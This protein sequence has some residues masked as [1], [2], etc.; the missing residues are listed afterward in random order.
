MLSTDNE[1]KSLFKIQ[2]TVGLMVLGF[3]ARNASFKNGIILCFTRVFWWANTF[4]RLKTWMWKDESG[5]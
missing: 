2:S 3:N 5:A 4:R 1:R